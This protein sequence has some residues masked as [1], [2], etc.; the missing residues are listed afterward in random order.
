MKNSK[1]LGPHILDTSAVSRKILE[2]R[3]VVEAYNGLS[4]KAKE[5]EGVINYYYRY[6]HIK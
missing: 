4:K 1:Y 6:Y 5:G 2:N 3:K